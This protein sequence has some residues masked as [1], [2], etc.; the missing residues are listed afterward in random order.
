MSDL[1]MKPQNK[2]TYGQVLTKTNSNCFA[3]FQ[4]FTYHIDSSVSN[5]RLAVSDLAHHQ[6]RLKA[7][8]EQNFPTAFHLCHHIS[9]SS[10][11]RA[12]GEFSAC[13]ALKLL[14]LCPNKFTGLYLYIMWLWYWKGGTVS[15]IWWVCLRVRWGLET[16]QQT[17]GHGNCR[18]MKWL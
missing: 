4:Y 5:P 1:V 16:G 15:D 13:T 6:T 9:L 8:V 17:D 18:S 11:A 14:H 7:S 12:H 3:K 10:T 2:T